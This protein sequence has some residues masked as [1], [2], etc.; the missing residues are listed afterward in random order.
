[1]LALRKRLGN[2]LSG[3]CLHKTVR[4]RVRSI[5][6]ARSI[7]P[8][9]YFIR[10]DRH[11]IKSSFIHN[12]PLKRVRSVARTVTQN[13]RPARPDLFDLHQRPRTS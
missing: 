6:R 1:M 5:G 3:K 11:T 4:R 9:N 2:L 13:V 8:Q 10:E 12:G 7:E